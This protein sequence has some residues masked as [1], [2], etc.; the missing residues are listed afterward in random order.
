MI[1]PASRWVFTVGGRYDR[2]ALDN[3][4][5]GGL[6]VDQTFSAFSP[7]ASAT[8]KLLG[9]HGAGKPAINLYAA[10]SRAFLPPRTPSS[11]TPA[12]AVLVLQPEDIN[13][14]EGGLKGSLLGGRVSLEA[15]YFHMTEDGVVLS[16]QQGPFF[17]PTNAGQ[18][19]YKGG[20]TGLSV[21]VTPKASAYVNAAFYRNRF[22]DFVI[23]SED[24]DEVLTGNRLPIS[25]NRVVNWGVRLTIDPYTLVDAAVTWRR[26]PLRTTLSAHNLFNEEYYWNA[27]GFTADPGRPRQVLFTVSVLF[28]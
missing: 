9:E 18:L 20:E 6:K 19:R 11:L 3:Q 27:D 5:E 15:T 7:K 10:Y 8:F 24:G 28:K 16:R 25:P 17:F 23:Q 12:N 22:G 26:G 2:L 14:I 4:P 13:N 21:A 1:E